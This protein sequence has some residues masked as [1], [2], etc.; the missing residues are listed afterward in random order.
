VMGADGA[1]QR[2]IGVNWDITDARAAQAARHER[3]IARRESEAK[4]KF[5][6]RMSHE[7]RTPLNAVLG[8]TQ[9]MLQDEAGRHGEALRRQWLQTIEAAGQ[10]LLSLIND[11]LDLTSVEGGEIRLEQRRVPVAPLF[12]EMLPLVQRQ[13]ADRGVTLRIDVADA[14]TSAWADPTRLRQVLLNLLSNAIKYNRPGGSALLRAVRQG[15]WVELSVADTGSGLNEQQQQHLFEPFN[16]LGVEAAGIEGTGIGLVIVK[17]LTERMGGS[18]VVDSAPGQG[19]V[20]TLRLPAADVEAAG[21][22]APP[23]GAPEAAAGRP[24]RTAAVL[25]VEDN[26]VNA[27]ILQELVARRPDIV[28]TVAADGRAGIEQARR[29]R[30]DLILLDMQLPD[31]DGLEVMRRLRAD[32]ATSDIRCVAV[33]A[34][35][36]PDEV[37]RARAAGVHDYWSKPIDLQVV[38]AALDRLLQPG[39]PG[40]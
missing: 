13:A 12:A 18:V 14:D 28:L 40:R 11:V 30:P 9:L 27:L 24:A 37:A 5:L 22:P 8:F 36:M 4:S 35:V 25:Y 7:L 33:S 21:D 6:A 16:R 23:D 1:P 26:P 20:F 17:S 29:L 3:E 19:S 34:N 39:M 15:P 10:H 38:L 31:I 32:P 2:R